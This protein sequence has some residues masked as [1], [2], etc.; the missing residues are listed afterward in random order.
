MA[1]FTGSAVAR[2][3]L[4][5][6]SLICWATGAAAEGYY[7]IGALQ[8]LREYV[9]A[10]DNA[11]FVDIVNPGEW[12][13]ISACGESDSDAIQVGVYDPVGNLVEPVHTIDAAEG[14]VSCSDSFT[15]PI[16][17]PYRVEATGTG[18][19]EVRFTNSNAEYLSR[20]DVTVTASSSSDPDPTGSKGIIGRL[21]S[22]NWNFNAIAFAEA[23][24]ADTNYYILA[25]G[26][27]PGT[28]YVWLLDLNN[29]AGFIY[30]ISS[31]GIGV[32]PPRSGFS[33]TEAGN[34]TVP[35]FYQYLAYP[36]VAGPLPTTPPSI[37]NFGFIDDAGEDIKFSPG[38]TAG[39]QD[40][41]NF[42]FTTDTEDAT[43]AIAIDIDQN[44]VY[45]NS[46]DVWLIGRTVNGVNTINWDGTDVNGIVVANGNYT[47]E[48]SVRLGEFHFVARDVETS[49]GSTAASNPSNG[50]GLTIYEATSSGG[51]IPALV[52]WDDVTVLGGSLT[53]YEPNPITVPQGELS[54]TTNS[55]HTWGDFT[56]TSFGNETLIDTFVY[57]LAQTSTAAAIVASDDTPSSGN[58]TGYAQIDASTAGGDIDLL[59]G[60]QDLIGAGT[61][62]ATVINARSGEVETVTL[63]ESPSQPGNFVATL[64]SA[65][66]A[67]PDGDGGNG[68]VNVLAGD[69]LVIT[70]EDAADASSSPQTI[71]DTDKV[72]GT[73][74]VP[75]ILMS[76]SGQPAELSVDDAD[77]AGAG[78]LDVTVINQTTGETETVT[79][80]ETGPSTGIFEGSLSTSDAT[81]VNATVGI[82]NTQ[83]LDQIRIDYDDALRANGQS[84]TVSDIDS[85]KEGASAFVSIDAAYVGQDVNLFLTDGDR[86]YQGSE[87]VTVTNLT[88]GES[89]SVTLGEVA[90][91]PGTFT[92]T[93]TTVNATGAGAST[94][95]GAFNAQ[96]GDNFEISYDDLAR[97]SG[98]PA[99]VT[100]TDTI[101]LAHTGVADIAGTLVGDPLSLEVSD[102]D[103][104][105][106]GTLIVTV[107]N[108]TTLEVETV[109]LTETGPSSGIFQGSLATSFGILSDGDGSNGSINAVAG[110]D[111]LLTYADAAG[112]DGSAASVTDS[113]TLSGGSTGTPSITATV[114]GQPLS[115]SVSDSDLAGNGTL[116]VTVTNATSGEVETVE[117]TEMAP[118]TGV[119]IGSL[120]TVNATGSDGNGSNGSINVL[121]ADVV[122]LSYDDAFRDDG[123]SGI[124]SDDA[125]IGEPGNDAVVTIT[126]GPVG[127]QAAI[128]LVDPDSVGAGTLSVEVTNPATGDTETIVLTED[129]GSPGTFNGQIDTALAPA[130]NTPENGT[131]GVS[132]GDTIAVS[133][134][135]PETSTGLPQ[136]FSD[137]GVVPNRDPV[138][139][140]DSA[141]TPPDTAVSIPVLINDYDPDGTMLVIQ[142][143]TQP[144]TGGTV[145]FTP[146]GGLVFTPDMGFTGSAAFTYTVEDPQGL[147]ATANVSV[148][149]NENA[150]TAVADIASTAPNTPV[151]IDVLANDVEPGEDPLTVIATT[152]P[153]NGVVLALPGGQILYTPDIAFT[154]IDVFTYTV[155][156]TAGLTDIATVTVTVAA[157]VP[158]IV[159]DSATATF[160]SSVNIAVLDNDTD[161]GNVPLTVVSVTQPA[162]GTATL[163]LDGSVSYTPNSGF[164]GIEVFSY[165]ACNDNGLC[166]SAT[167]RVTVLPPEANVTGVVFDD[168]DHDGSPD[169][170]EPRRDGWTV[171]LVRN[172]SVISTGT[173]I[174]DG[175]FTII[176]VAPRDDYELLFI[177]PETGVVWQHLTNVELLPGTTTFDQDLPI[178]P[179]GVVYDLLTRSPQSGIQLVIVDSGGTPLP[180]TCLADP[181]QQGQTTGSD[182]RY[183][184]DL[185]PGGDAACPAGETFYELTVLDSLGDPIAR[186]AS[187]TPEAG[188]LD[189]TGSPP[190]HAVVP[191]SG[192]PQVGDPTTYYMT[193]LLE[194]GDP[195]VVNNHIPVEI[196]TQSALAADKRAGRLTVSR[197]DL[198]PYTITIT[199]SE[200]V[201][202]SGLTVV[203]TLPAA[204]AYKPDSAMVNGVF[205]EPV[206]AGNTITWTG[207]AVPASGSVTLQ[208]LAVTGSQLTIG[209]H[210]NSAY[211]WNPA[212]VAQI[213]NVATAT[214]EFAPDP[215]FDCPTVIGRVFNDANGNGMLDAGEEGIKGVR[216]ATVKGLLITTGEHGRYNL[217][218]PVVPNSHIGSN[219]VLKLDPRTLPQ[220]YMLTGPNP[221]SVRL[222]RGK[223]SK[224]N[225]T[226]LKLARISLDFSAAAFVAARTDLA[227]AYADGV[228]RIADTL[229]QNRGAL[230]LRY[231]AVPGE[232]ELARTR[233]QAIQRR[234]EAEW[235]RRGSPYDLAIE[236]TIL[237]SGKGG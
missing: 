169:P 91:S 196:T 139:A 142:S 129:A 20:Y 119:F 234:I 199:N 235:R 60:D 231:H 48:L 51:K 12:I 178:D 121:P 182:G 2:T 52:Y 3:V 195:D 9:A 88:T 30:E 71:T 26:G 150:P 44:G 28:N 227:P 220:G 181:T 189:P 156:N 203:D 201:D 27:Y 190:P 41:G 90:G 217:P 177:H 87:T 77:L 120:S 109:T 170:D 134:D 236:R 15:S 37:S 191:N 45:G 70:Y 207:I 158:D 21:S 93:V 55:Y 233:L 31:N 46:G 58:F 103:I 232:R 152:A 5:V 76:T 107:T 67:A 162:N 226:V 13:N 83:S 113:V 149:V 79:L 184:F 173:T 106:T 172:G 168:L 97:P 216:L 108:Q 96:D 47:A 82:M 147:T 224:V 210:T 127:T 101:A 85:V 179:S 140:D 59:V 80:A 100:A 4:L 229:E 200:S 183:R 160:G 131:L 124:A 208:Y 53:S 75:S 186:P 138:A 6:L 166:G 110:D 105:G 197:G 35:E 57:G 112:A 165:T 132:P 42:H 95:D 145:T 228:R 54:G 159:D 36:I 19:Y 43:Y 171:Q 84:L 137:N 133:Y 61:L 23:N 8:R 223:M 1:A 94:S 118:A 205:A 32:D 116:T 206:I 98:S 192:A 111:M 141:S 115:L 49:G 63:T 123:S 11:L 29:L 114:A 163:N 22:R 153:A 161:P 130:G 89:E 33:T 74:G 122:T 219:F 148:N 194:A 221:Q 64:S 198:V 164:Y 211:V 204:F 66:G 155:Q 187:V 102:S 136:T 143:V 125:T 128:T 213:S 209:Q 69:D 40:S 14:R 78:T 144:A 225:F 230:S 222:T 180:N 104:A 16:P 50:Y 151:A 24:A 72:G 10:S 68:S 34:T 99:T 174:A 215:D 154:G 18:R 17:N 117:L 193:F 218:C 188:P 202:R 175:S 214:V 81:G 56:G 7:Q 65:I 185:V 157:G 73:D 237:T 25:P 167:V 38:A 176:G 126:P 212:T 135:D 39:I 92:G 86:S 62:A 146:D